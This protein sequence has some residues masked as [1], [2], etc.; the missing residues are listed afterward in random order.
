MKFES[1]ERYLVGAS[2]VATGFLFVLL[3]RGAAFAGAARAEAAHAASF[4][5]GAP[6]QS[7]V[8]S[9]AT[10]PLAAKVPREVTVQ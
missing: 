1:L 8:P 5:Q 4:G 3:L 6:V 9:T 10:G 2:G 7:K